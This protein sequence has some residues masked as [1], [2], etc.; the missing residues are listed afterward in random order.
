MSYS[1]GLRNRSGGSLGT[2]FLGRDGAPGGG[3]GPNMGGGGDSSGADSRG[4]L[5]STGHYDIKVLQQKAQM[6]EI[7]RWEKLAF[8]SFVKA[9]WLALIRVSRVHVMSFKLFFKIWTKEVAT[10]VEITMFLNGLLSFL[11]RSFLLSVTSE[12]VN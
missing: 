12:Y 4:V 6:A 2:A 7:K 5:D 9:L 10:Q 8:L 1:R 11:Q 3:G